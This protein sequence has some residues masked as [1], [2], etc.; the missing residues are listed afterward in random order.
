MNKK[1]RMVLW[2]GVLLMI[3]MGLFPP[4]HVEAFQ[5]PWQNN[6]DEHVPSVSTEYRYQFIGSDNRIFIDEVGAAVGSE[7]GWARLRLQWLGVVLVMFVFMFLFR[8]RGNDNGGLDYP[9]PTQPTA[10]QRSE[11]I[12]VA[13]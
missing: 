6:F 1:Q 9:E 10:P 2:I 3:I 11:S 8:D 7:I 4:V 5:P 12:S 13:A